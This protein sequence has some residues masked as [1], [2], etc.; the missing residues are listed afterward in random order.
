MVGRREFSD[1]DRLL[2]RVKGTE[3]G[4]RIYVEDLKIEGPLTL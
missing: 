3:N 2:V 1:M 4:T